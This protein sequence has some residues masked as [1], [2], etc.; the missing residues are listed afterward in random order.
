MISGSL[1]TGPYLLRFDT[2]AS[3]LDKY[4]DQVRYVGSY[5]L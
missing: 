3:G 2:Y 4:T 5:W 1:L